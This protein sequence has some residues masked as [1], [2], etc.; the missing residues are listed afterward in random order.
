MKL[1][2]LIGLT[3]SEN[4]VLI[5]TLSYYKDIYDKKNEVKLAINND[6]ISLK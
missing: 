4:E 5:L 1:Y 6:L 3:W 2:F